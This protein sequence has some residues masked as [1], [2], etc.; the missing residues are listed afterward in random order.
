MKRRIVSLFALVLILLMLFS[1]CT[2]RQTPFLIGTYN[3]DEADYKLE[4]NTK[5]EIKDVSDMLYGIFFEDINFAADGGLYAEMA[6]NRSFEFTAP[7]KDEQ[8]YRWSAVGKAETEV[9]INDSKN[10]LNEN[11]TNYLIINNPTDDLAGVANSGFLEGMAVEDSEYN[12]SMYAK[13]LDGY[14]GRIIVRIVSG[15]KCLSEGV[16]TDV[17]DGWNKY[18]ISLTCNE[19]SSKNVKLQVLVEKGSVAVDMVSLFPAETF[20]GEE[21]G[22]RNDIASKLEELQPKFLRFPG[23]CITEGTDESTAYSWKDSV[24]A[25][26]DGN[27]FEWNGKY[28]DVAARKQGTNLWMNLNG[29]DDEYPS[30]MT[31]GLGF[32]EFFRLAED[33]GAVGVPVLNCGLYCQSRVKSA[34]EIGTKEFDRY[35]DDMLDLVEFCRGDVNTPWGKVRQ[36]LGHEQPFELK[37]ICIGNENFGE[38]YYERYNEFVKAFNNAKKNNPGLYK[39]IE[40]IYSSGVDDST[41]SEDYIN[42]YKYAS[43][44]L[45]DKKNDFAGAVDQHYYNDPSWFLKNSDY[46]DEKNYSRTV[47]GMTENNG[48]KINVFLGE[49]ASWSNT[50][51]SALAESAYM[52][53]L[54]RNGDIVKMAT[55]AP[56]LASTTASHWSPNLIWFNNQEVT[57]SANYYTQKIFSLNQSSGILESTLEGAEAEKQ[58]VKIN[59]K[60]GVGTW[61]TSASFDNIKVTS[62]VDGAVLAE[63]DFSSGSIIGWKKDKY[64]DFVVE[65]GKLIQKSSEAQKGDR[66]SIMFFGDDSWENYT[67]TMDAE[68][69]DGEEG[70]FIPFAANKGGHYYW[71]I[72]GFG[73]TNSCLQEMRDGEKSGQLEWTVKNF[74]V[75]TGKVYHLKIEVNEGTIKCYIDDEL[76]VDYDPNYGTEYEA[77]HVAGTD[78]N[79]DVII[80]LV[81]VTDH[82]KTFAINLGSEKYKNAQITQVIG[83][84]MDSQNKQGKA[85]EVEWNENDTDL[86]G[87]ES[88]FNFTVPKC[89]VTVIRLTSE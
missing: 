88:Q 62:N 66:G 54:E 63:D 46:Y 56:L 52:T 2:T 83:K 60:I 39:D 70:F 77:Y 28:G 29:K 4:V 86:I 44:K 43:D 32:Y 74:V 31:Y 80:K 15:S 24:G 6:A 26:K 12:F 13:P 84:D 47:D 82:S 61:G 71:N 85:P 53:G 30:F 1:A 67:V 20:K 14:N 37:Y 72:G 79:G 58:P 34:V 36:S 27:P 18:E 5:N 21:N 35:I 73:N 48:G 57:P 78:E 76:Y 23:G 81:N 64:G 9:K 16:F 3:S 65:D 7:A 10:C 45:S 89:S 25:D 11:N 17:K 50:M 40:L 49:Y 51:Y 22:L 55:Y 69:L 19:K 87:F 41:G 8:M 38:V 75:E 59:G 33:I 42:S 68:K